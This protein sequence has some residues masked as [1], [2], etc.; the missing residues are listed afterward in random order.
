MVRV[1]DT[2][3]QW[4]GVGRCSV[5]VLSN[6]I[7]IA[8]NAVLVGYPRGRW[9]SGWFQILEIYLKHSPEVGPI[10]HKSLKSRLDHSGKYNISS[11]L[12]LCV[13]S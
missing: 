10:C 12:S 5:G 8:Q 11:Q 3:S 7:H 4:I 6:L 2:R 1:P 9:D 13:R